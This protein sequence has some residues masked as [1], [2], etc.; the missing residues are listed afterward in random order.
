MNYLVAG[1]AG[2][3]GSNL[4][5]KLLKN[6]HRVTCLDNLRTGS[7]DNVS[8]FIDNN[9][10]TFVN[11]DVRS[12]YANDEQF[13]RVFNLACPASPV[14]YQVN[15]IDTMVVNIIGTK[16]MLDVARDCN[17]VFVQ[18]STSEIYGEPMIHPQTE[19]YR[20]N[21]NPIG[22]RA[23][24]D[25]GKRGAEALCFD[26]LR[27]HGVKIKVARL[28]N[29]YGPNMMADDGRVISNFIV[30]ALDGKKLTINGNGFQ[31]R[32][33][34]YVYDMV[35]ALI[36]LSE[37]GDN[38]NGPVNLGNPS[39]C[40][41]LDLAS[42]VVQKID[43]SLSVSHMPLPQDDPTRRKPSIELAQRVLR[44]TPETDLSSGLDKTI[45]FFK[46]RLA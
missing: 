36:L 16:N 6:G 35:E 26:Y 4:C 11:H 18:A 5:G 7:L 37:S 9:N 10:F 21:V 19:D 28:F 42:L 30:Q 43:P 3:I 12:P 20:G 13:D 15:P 44:W 2:F 31:T 22:P 40:T 29:T 39:E 45:A 14:Q 32:C 1:G 33:F 34:C 24:Y 41:I 23:C 25:E 38:F 8:D 17:A 46:R 27:K